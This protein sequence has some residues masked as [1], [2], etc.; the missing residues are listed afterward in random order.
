MPRV[1]VVVPAYR[2]A[3][4]IAST[5]DSILAQT[6]DDLEV[7]VADHSSDDRTQSILERYAEDPRV[8]LLSPT[9]RGGG[10]ARNWNRVTEAAEGELIKLVCGDDLIHPDCLALQVAAFDDDQELV[11]VSSRRDLVDGEGRLLRRGHTV[12]PRLGGTMSGR[13]AI[14]ATVRSGTNIFGEPAAVLMRRD[15]LAAAGGWDAR[16][17]YYIDA[18]TYVQAMAD[19]RVRRLSDSLATFRVSMGQWSV[20]LVGEQARSARAFHAF[21][22]RTWPETV[23]AADVLRGNALALAGAG[24]RRVVYQVM[25]AERAWTERRRR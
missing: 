9:P 3:Q 15:S 2:N 21:A 7:V 6:Y 22:R 13:D 5:M 23:S 18:Q 1:S 11:L 17:D 25:E 4:H 24:M 10:A 8:R 14:R 20:R 12:A 19:G 16:N